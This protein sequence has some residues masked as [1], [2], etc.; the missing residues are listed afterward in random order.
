[1]NN[2]PDRLHL[3]ID[4]EY[5]GTHCQT[6]LSQYSM[7]FYAVCQ[8]AR[9][10]I[11]HWVNAPWRRR[12]IS[13]QRC[14]QW[15]GRFDSCLDPRK[16]RFPCHAK[17]L[18]CRYQTRRTYRAW[19]GTYLLK[20]LLIKWVIC[21][22]SVLKDLTIFLSKSN[23]LC[24]TMARAPNSALSLKWIACSRIAEAKLPK[25]C[26]ILRCCDLLNSITHHKLTSKIFNSIR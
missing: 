11:I 4:S 15:F 2:Y 8:R 17:F 13:K 21:A 20:Q 25:Y 14:L 23:Q 9:Q 12:A 1:M 10:R 6:A 7:I 26:T 3:E 22:V 18:C 16:S 24:L 19:F 5:V